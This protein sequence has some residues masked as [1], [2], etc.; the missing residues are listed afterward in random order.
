LTGR[1]KGDKPLF[2]GMGAVKD[3]LSVY[4]DLPEEL[5]RREG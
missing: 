4:E 2:A 5:W 3:D 1:T